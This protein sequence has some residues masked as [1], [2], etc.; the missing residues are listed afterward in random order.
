MLFYS[1]LY[2]RWLIIQLHM[3]SISK[4]F[5]LILYCKLTTYIYFYTYSS[6]QY[7]HY[8][9]WFKSFCHK[10]LKWFLLAERTFSVNV[11]A[12]KLVC[13]YSTYIT[14][15]SFFLY[16]SPG[17]VVCKYWRVFLLGL[18]DSLDLFIHTVQSISIFSFYLC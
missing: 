1:S 6:W 16:Y 17:V 13:I 4:P 5:F 18:L 9:D 15:F 7:L 8:F 10:M 12:P 11:S 2:C 14:C 3:S